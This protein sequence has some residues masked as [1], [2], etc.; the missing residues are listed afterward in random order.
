MN[1]ITNKIPENTFFYPGNNPYLAD[2][3][4][5][6]VDIKEKTEYPI[7]LKE[8]DKGQLYFKPDF[9]FNLPKGDMRL[10]IRSE[11]FNHQ[12]NPRNQALYKLLPTFLIH[13]ATADLYDANTAG[14]SYKYSAQVE[15]LVINAKGISQ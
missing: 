2:D 1:E 12:N 3:L 10:I 7:L 14:F 9:T 8:S 11:K 4:S 13:I 6:K 15:G 5:L